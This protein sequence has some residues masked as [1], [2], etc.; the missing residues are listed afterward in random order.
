MT[1]HFDPYLQGKRPEL[2][3]AENENF[4]AILEEKPLVLGHCVVFSKR[5]EDAIFDLTDSELSG[6][7]PFAKSIA[8]AMKQILPCQ[9]IGIAALGL[10]VRHAHLHLVPIN[11]ADDLNFTRPKLETTPAEL[12]AMAMRIR[13]GLQEG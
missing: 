12:G 13:K 2:V 3:I 10:Q 9:K 8:H 6:L 11:S 7:L 1:S 5:V 4:M